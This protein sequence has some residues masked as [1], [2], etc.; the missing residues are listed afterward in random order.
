VLYLA[1]DIQI[2]NILFNICSLWMLSYNYEADIR[3]RLFIII[4]MYGIGIMVE[5]VIWVFSGNIGDKA[6]IFNS[7]QYSS[8]SGVILNHLWLFVIVIFFKNIREIRGGKG[9]PALYWACL[10]AVPLFSIYFVLVLIL[11]SNAL[12]VQ[13]VLS[14]IALFIVNISI[15]VLYNY[16]VKSMSD[17]VEGMLLEEQNKSYQEQLKIM[18]SSYLSIKTLKHD[19][20][21]HFIVL[22]NM[23][24]MNQADLASKYIE[25]ILE[26]QWDAK[27]VN[28]G[29]IVVDSIL[30]FKL[31][32][33]ENE[34]IP[35]SLKFRIPEQLPIALKDM[36]ALLGN[37]F[38][39]AIEAVR[40]LPGEERWINMV[41]RYDKGCLIIEESNPY[42]GRKRKNWKT[43]KED[44]ENHGMGLY[45]M[46]RIAESY[47]GWCEIDG[48]KENI[49][50]VNI[51]LRLKDKSDIS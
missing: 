33:A 12:T 1:V 47:D 49:F 24:H 23:L 43:I 22:Q 27:K 17:Q 37:I 21:N 41:M 20:K 45:H 35:C 26:E 14:I 50:M 36:V 16:V 7:Q 13:M 3:K 32:N 10:V 11:T 40:R 31:Q 30:G 6:S 28:S 19:L 9:M 18:Q 39:N 8:I 51:L 29:N 15:S 5:S 48:E 4:L 2:L 46:K 38:D 42:D 44:K 34:N 25:E